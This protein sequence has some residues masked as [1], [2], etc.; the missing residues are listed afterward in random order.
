MLYK[1]FLVEDE[2]DTREGIRD[3]VNWQSTGFTL[4]G[5]AP[6]GEIALP[7]IEQTRPDV[8]ITDIKMP[9]MDGLQLCKLVKQRLSGVRI[10]IL[11]GH[12]EFHYAQ[13]AVKL[14]VTEYLLKPI[15]VKDLHQALEK[16]AGQI[17]AEQEEKAHLEKMTQHAEENKVARQEKLLLDIIT[18]KISAT[19]AIE[20]SHQTGLDIVATCFQVI[21][22]KIEAFAGKETFD[23]DAFEQT[24]AII[25][26]SVANHPDVFLLRKNV[27]E[28]IL[29]L[30]GHS[31]AQLKRESAF[32][33]D[34]L[35]REVAAETRCTLQIGVGSP[36]QRL[37]DIPLS[38]A[39]ALA[40]LHNQTKK[41][42]HTEFNATD[43]TELLQLDK[44][45]LE[46]YL[47]FGAQ[48]D[49]DRFFDDYIRPLSTNAF[50]SYL[51]KN[52]I[53][54]D[55]V[56]NTAKFVHQLGGNI[57]QVLPEVHTVE[58][59]LMNINTLEQI[60][61]EARKIFSRALAFRDRQAG[62]PYAALIDQAKN[63]ILAHYANPD[64]S[65]ND[66]AEH[67]N[68]SPSHFSTI[69]SRET[70]NTFKDYLSAL[71]IDK[72]KE[73][74]KT[75][76]LKSFEVAVLVGYND[77]HYFSTVFKKNTGYSPSR[78]KTRT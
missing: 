19:E 69:F 40:Q 68:L 4:C 21:A 25:L 64:L 30:K 8:L 9:F 78:Y 28:R 56:L 36:Q 52:Y 13:E 18:G 49:F 75:T 54:I 22:L 16:V 42:P 51:S 45:R 60:R 32:L 65:L 74:L 50:N 47:K 53:F 73:L 62:N 41:S 31:P 76:P 48:A 33:I 24:K 43:K 37:G 70:K 3:N 17:H 23:Y 77:P 11:S 66:V 44:T 72:A 29:L 6:D 5:E 7:L 46:N 1:A 14:G 71:R 15:G 67:V 55:M 34:L 63:Y 38:L 61:N 12:D 2:I 26:H 58:T 10:I 20:Q 39:E 59:M 57:D 35:K 27:E